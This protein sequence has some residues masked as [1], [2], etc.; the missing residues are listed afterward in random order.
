MAYLLLGFFYFY[1]VM[2]GWSISKAYN[3][4]GL[5]AWATNTF[6]A[7]CWLGGEAYMYSVY[8]Q[9]RVP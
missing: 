2:F 4:T 6:M 5:R 1:S 8:C 7:A 9:I 3:A